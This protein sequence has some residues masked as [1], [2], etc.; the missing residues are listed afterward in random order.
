M[1]LLTV[2]PHFYTVKF[3]KAIHANYFYKIVFRIFKKSAL[4]PSHV[5]ATEAQR[6]EE[7][8]ARLCHS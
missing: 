7:T 2:N 5:L 4:N 6:D 1:M 3:E 8:N